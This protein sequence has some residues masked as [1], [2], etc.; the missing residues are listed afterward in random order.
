MD[1]KHSPKGVLTS[2]FVQCTFTLK[3]KMKTESSVGNDR[4]GL[5][6]LPAV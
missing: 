6:P 1:Q 3:N 2:V 5:L 4:R